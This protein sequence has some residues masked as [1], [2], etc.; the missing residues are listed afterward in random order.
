MSITATLSRYDIIEWLMWNDWNGVYGDGDSIR[1]F[2][3]K[4]TREEG[5]EIMP[6][7]IKENR[8]IEP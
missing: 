7:Q 5:L 6:R 4:M 8:V 2:G 1:E 3:V